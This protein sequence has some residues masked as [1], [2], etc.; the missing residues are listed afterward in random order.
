[1]YKDNYKDNLKNYQEVTGQVDSEGNKLTTNSDS[2][3]RYHSSWLNM[4]YPRMILAR[5]LLSEKGVIFV[6]IDDKEQAN[7]KKLMDDIF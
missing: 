3:G 5:N 6:S 4:I 1:M 2:D 7:L